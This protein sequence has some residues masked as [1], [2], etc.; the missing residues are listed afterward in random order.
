VRGIHEQAMDD[1][2][3]FPDLDRALEWAEE[4]LLLDYPLTVTLSDAPG[5]PLGD[6]GQG[7]AEPARLA[8]ERGMV[9]LRYTAG[10]LI[11][12]NGDQDRRLMLVQQGEVTLS[13]AES[14][15]QG[16][17]LASIGPGVVFGEM[18]FLNGIP[19]TAYAHASSA[20]AV[21]CTLE[22]D[23]FKKWSGVHP[24]AALDFMKELARLGIRRLGTTSQE[25]R[26]AME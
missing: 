26:A 6:L 14:P 20:T 3:P 9:T 25:L 8:L 5:S 21:V 17:R 24:E 1:L 10:A 13:T 2:Q 11:I 12:R 7:M 19:R 4:Q 22:W 23:V 15:G 18:A 16:L